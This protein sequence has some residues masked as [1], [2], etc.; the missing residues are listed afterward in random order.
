MAGRMAGALS[1]P[2]VRSGTAV[3]PNC[4]A[5]RPSDR[6][7]VL[8]IRREAGAPF[9][10][11]WSSVRTAPSASTAAGA[12]VVTA[13]ASGW[14][15][16]DRAR[17]SASR[18]RRIHRAGER[19]D[20]GEPA[21]ADRCPA[22]RRGPFDGACRVRRAERETA[23]VVRRCASSRSGFA[24]SPR[25][26]WTRTVKRSERG[27]TWK[28]FEVGPTLVGAN[29]DTPLAQVKSVPSAET[30]RNEPNTERAY[31]PD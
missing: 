14:R 29:L 31:S 28:L 2:R 6:V 10:A 4:S 26:S 23:T 16:A 19:H 5:R 8:P 21:A 27:P 12:G 3:P 17:A 22:R 11:A 15:R 13:S 30:A 7:V 20:A 1:L 9:Q 18:A 25:G 24:R